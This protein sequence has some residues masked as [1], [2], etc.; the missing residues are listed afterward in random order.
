MIVWTG[1]VGLGSGW[2]FG[3]GLEA[4]DGHM[5]IWDDDMWTRIEMG[6]QSMGK[7]IGLQSGE[8]VCWGG[9]ARL[10]KCL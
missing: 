5:D 3:L 7:E 4:W 8:E 10:L 6:V 1:H 9:F 2:G